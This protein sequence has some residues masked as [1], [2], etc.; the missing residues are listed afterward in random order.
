MFPLSQ[1]AP[2]TAIALL[3][4]TRNWIPVRLLQLL[5]CRVHLD[6][7]LEIGVSFRQVNNECFR[8]DVVTSYA[9]SPSVVHIGKEHR[10]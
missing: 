9:A 7:D 10:K 5:G 1:F 8:K 3:S 6:F 2:G 4:R